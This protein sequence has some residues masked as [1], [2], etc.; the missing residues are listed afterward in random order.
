MTKI[1]GTPICTN[2]YKF[3]PIRQAILTAPL[4]LA[5]CS[6]TPAPA[7]TPATSTCAK[8]AAMPQAALAQLD[9][10][11][12]S[13][14]GGTLW[15]DT[16]AGCAAASTTAPDWTGMVF[17]ELKAILPQVLPTVLPL[18]IGLL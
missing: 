2:W 9:A 14:A 3:V 8:V 13:S 5:A 7:A 10:Q 4:W 15:A 16:K 11:D 1:I 17:G 6:L 18:L 12:P